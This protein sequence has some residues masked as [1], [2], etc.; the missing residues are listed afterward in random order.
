MNKNTQEDF[1][2][3]ES[4]VKNFV[5]K[6]NEA[7]NI[8]NKTKQDLIIIDLYSFIFVKFH[9]LSVEDFEKLINNIP[10]H[11]LR[12]LYKKAKENGSVSVSLAN[13]LEMAA[14]GKVVHSTP[15]H[16]SQEDEENDIGL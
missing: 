3:Q 8:Q 11:I 1:E 14:E 6:Y 5:S 10:K 15:S 7:S 9:R 12:E 2:Y 4:V 13:K 16:P